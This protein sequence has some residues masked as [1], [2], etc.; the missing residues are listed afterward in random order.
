V[1]RAAGVC[2]AQQRAESGAKL[3]VGVGL[4]E[5]VVGAALQQPRA[6]QLAC[7]RCEH[8]DRQLWIDVRAGVLPDRVDNAE[9]VAVDIDD[10][11]VGVADSS[12]SAAAVSA[13]QTG[14]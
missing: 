10:Q 1:G 8:E 11:R 13:A 12:S 9:R 7:V 2:A 5:H 3:W 6:V 14:R 4:A